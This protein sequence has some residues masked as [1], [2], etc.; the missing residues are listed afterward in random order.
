MRA[1]VEERIAQGAAASE[2]TRSHRLLE[3]YAELASTGTALYFGC[4][5]K[6]K[7]LY[8]SAE[9][10]EWRRQGVHVRVAC[11][12]DQA[13]IHSSRDCDRLFSS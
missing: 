3:G 8:F 12:R 5:S 4:R 7:D 2:F 10:Y 11:S 1:F 6:D 9:M 13:S